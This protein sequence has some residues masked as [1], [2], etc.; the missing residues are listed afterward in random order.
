MRVSENYDA[1]QFTKLSQIAEL[2]I[3]GRN[4]TAAI[5]NKTAAAKTRL[6]RRCFIANQIRQPTAIKL[7]IPKVKRLVESSGNTGMR[8]SAAGIKLIA[9]INIK[10]LCSAGRLR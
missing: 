7:G 9:V 1:I 5:N 10:D 3:I 2:P 6:S 4:G 8:K